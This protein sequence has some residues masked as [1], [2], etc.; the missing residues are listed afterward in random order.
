MKC[1]DE[2][3]FQRFVDGELGVVARGRVASHVRKCERCRNLVDRLNGE[4]SE[5]SLLLGEEIAVPDLSRPIMERIRTAPG[6]S[7]GK[8]RYRFLVRGLQ[9]AAAITLVVLFLIFLFQ[10]R[11]SGPFNGNRDV[12]IRTAMVDGQAVQTHVFTSVESDIK[13]IWLEKM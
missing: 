7:P 6:P 1:H 3:I 10:N 5:I 2:S 13:F 4:N 12:L 8:F 11:N 9:F